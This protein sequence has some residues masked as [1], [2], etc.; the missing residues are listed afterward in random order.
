MSTPNSERRWV[1]RLIAEEKSAAILLL[2][3]GVLGLLLAN[4]LGGSRT[5]ALLHPS[6]AGHGLDLRWLASDGFLVVFFFVAGLELRH[7]LTLGALSTV[8][9][10]AVPV[11]AAACGMALPAV[12]YLALSPASAR[13]AWGVPMATDL[14][15]ALALVA[16]AGRGLPA[17][18]R[19]FILSLAIVDDVLSI[20]VIA[21]A[22]GANLS[23]L[24]CSITVGLVVLYAWAQTRSGPVASIIAL[25]AWFAMLNT[26]VHATVL[27]VV[28]GLMTTR[29]TDD[30]RSRWQPFAALF[31]VPFFVMTALAVPLSTTDVDG[32]VVAA[33]TLARI[34]GKPFGIVIGAALAIAVF[35]PTMKLRLRAYAVAGSVAA[36]GFSVSMLFAE[37][38]LREQLLAKT[39][40]AI[41]I[42]LVV[43]APLAAF[44]IR[45][46]RHEAATG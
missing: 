39:N 42:A 6:L 46:L 24:W 2:L 13:D 27:G 4:V 14:P 12:I 21:V 8:R 5:Q 23:V 26:G 31:A 10:A 15:L 28:L 33:V 30:V 43:S 25:A 38:G 41:L 34:V 36:L 1:Q 44:A 11:V 20:L 19:A 17:A 32:P 37:L 35:K 16:V 29:R 45:G 18:F 3:A 7:E 40:F 22:F 9:D